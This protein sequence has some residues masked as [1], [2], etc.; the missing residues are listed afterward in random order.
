M[1]HQLALADAM[2]DLDSIDKKTIDKY[3]NQ[4]IKHYE[5]KFLELTNITILD[6]DPNYPH[7]FCSNCYQTTIQLI[8]NRYQHQST[9]PA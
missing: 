6:P 4:R 2:L 1:I 3:V 5:K 9:T 7:K 8:V